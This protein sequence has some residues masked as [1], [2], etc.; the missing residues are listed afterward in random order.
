MSG[1][2]YWRRDE[3]TPAPGRVISGNCYRAL[4]GLSG[5]I[6]V[7]KHVFVWYNDMAWYNSAWFIYRIITRITTKDRVKGVRIV[8]SLSLVHGFVNEMKIE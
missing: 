2:E 3:W 5:L 4:D 7:K 6:C 8:A 1:G